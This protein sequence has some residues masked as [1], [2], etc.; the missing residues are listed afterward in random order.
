MSVAVLRD[1]AARPVRAVARGSAVA[2]S[3]ER[4][5]GQGDLGGAELHVVAPAR[6]G[7]EGVGE[8]GDQRVRRVRRRRPG[9]EQPRLAQLAAAP[10]P[11]RCRRPAGRP[12]ANAADTRPT[13]L[14][15]IRL[16]RR[17]RRGRPAG[18][19]T[20]RSACRV[21]RSSACGSR[22][23]SWSPRNVPGPVARADPDLEVA[24]C[25]AG[26]PTSSSASAARS[27][28]SA[29]SGCGRAVAEQPGAG[30]Q[31]HVVVR[32][33]VGELEV[34]A[35][36]E[37]AAL[38]VDRP[39]DAVEVGGRGSG[40]SR[41]PSAARRRPPAC[42]SFRWDGL[43]VERAGDDV[44]AVAL[45]AVEGDAGASS[46]PKTSPAPRTRNHGERAVAPPADRRPGSA[47]ATCSPL[48][49]SR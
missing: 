48:R 6:L 3:P 45:V 25:G 7:V 27:R 16:A 35:G 4:V 10:G 38:D 15:L 13:R 43:A 21:S 36:V 37:P 29:S 32:R 47:R 46:A 39:A 14:G 41:A 17:A 8:C 42:A 5:R 20:N 23:R 11:G 24:G 44:R 9:V 33:G 1:E 22:H 31:Q 18:A 26:R 2:G 49:S 19:T 12:R 30:E 40:P 34:V 28:A